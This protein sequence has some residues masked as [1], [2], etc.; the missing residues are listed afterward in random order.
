M[1]KLVVSRANLVSR[2]QKRF[3]EL[4]SS[5]QISCA[6]SKFG[7]EKPKKCFVELVLSGQI[8]GALVEFGFECSNYFSIE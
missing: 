6:S 4:V 1:F 5:G 2:K 7:I 8:R 3:V